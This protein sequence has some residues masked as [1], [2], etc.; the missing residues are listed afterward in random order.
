[1]KSAELNQDGRWHLGHTDISGVF[2]PKIGS[3]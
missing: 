2:D 1:M 3:F